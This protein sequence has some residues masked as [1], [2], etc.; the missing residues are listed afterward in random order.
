MRIS[1]LLGNC[2]SAV[3]KMISFLM[4]SD[5]KGI[6]FSIRDIEKLLV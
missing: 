5:L 6:S 3:L 2:F 1:K 4:V